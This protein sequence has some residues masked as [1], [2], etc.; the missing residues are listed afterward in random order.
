MVKVSDILGFINKIA[1]PTL[2]ESWDNPGLQVG[3][4]T[5][6]VNRIM[7]ALDSSPPVIEAAI[8]SR[9]NL[10]VTHHPLIFK[11]LSSVST[12]TPHGKSIHDAIENKLSIIALHTNY[13]SADGGLND[14]LAQKIGLLS[15]TP[16][17]AT[18]TQKLVKLVVYVPSEH[19]E[20]VRSAMLPFAEKLGKYSDCSFA[21][22]GLGT[23]TPLSGASPFV[24]KEGVFERV[25]EE[26]LELLMDQDVMPKA[27][28]SLRLSHPYEEPAFDVYPLLNQG[29]SLGLGRIGR[30]SSPLPLEAYAARLAGILRS[31]GLRYVGEAAALVSKV[32]LCS[33]SGASMI[34][35]A[36]RAGAD[37]LVTGDL[38][39]HEAR[40]A[41]D[42]EMA[43][44]DAGHFPTE[45]IMV[46]AVAEQLKQMISEF[47]NENC[48]VVQCSSE[49]D[50]FQICSP[51]N[52]PQ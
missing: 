13:D 12:A 21:A 35:A 15:C 49:R 37:L 27:L 52:I 29:R 28:K 43:V 46:A 26:R 1:P 32:A 2:A 50:P 42:L 31:P 17:Q 7:V 11:P 9:C 20:S 18:W 14:L 39:Y 8:R 22:K 6:E 30:L 16:L 48:E 25:A 47:G 10:L 19:L 40:D 34:K 38:K 51:T 3:N 4:P 24:G 5:G 36:K 44:I 23:F 45:I 33:G 41:E